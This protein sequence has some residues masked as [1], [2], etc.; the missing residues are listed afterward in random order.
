MNPTEEYNVSQL[1][2]ND[3]NRNSV[4]Q[5][6]NRSIYTVIRYHTSY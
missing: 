4:Q 6:T 2:G 1:Q 3:L 5:I